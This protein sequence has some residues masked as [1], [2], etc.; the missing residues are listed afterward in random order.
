MRNFDW[1]LIKAKLREAILVLPH[2]FK[3]PVQGMRTLPHWE[4]PE[5][6]ILQALFAA[7]CALIG[8]AIERDLLGMVTGVVLAPIAYMLMITIGAGFFYYIFKFSF[9]REIPY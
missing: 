8:S 4:W 6:L 7:A 3:N 2:F 5:T 1:P 9:Q